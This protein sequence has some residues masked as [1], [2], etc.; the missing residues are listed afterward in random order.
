MSSK[1]RKG[2]LYI[3]H[4][5]PGDKCDRFMSAVGLAA[6]MM[7]VES[8]IRRSVYVLVRHGFPNDVLSHGHSKRAVEKNILFGG[9]KG[10]SFKVNAR[11]WRSKNQQAAKERGK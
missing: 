10:K 3:R 8:G 6:A 5:Q 4:I 1:H 7:K 9:G 11:T 2:V